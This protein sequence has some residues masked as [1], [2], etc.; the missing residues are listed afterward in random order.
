MAH[1]KPAVAVEILIPIHTSGER[2]PGLGASVHFKKE[3]VL[4]AIA[5]CCLL[6]KAE[7][8]VGLNEHTGG[9]VGTGQRRV[10]D[11]SQGRGCHDD[12]SASD[13]G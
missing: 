3:K 7:K 4:K 10:P 5:V 1:G 9:V 13:S 12:C 11:R 8:S 6:L 2:L